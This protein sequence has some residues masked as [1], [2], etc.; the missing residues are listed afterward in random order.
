LI[1]FPW[2]IKTSA[3]CFFILTILGVI[4]VIFDTVEINFNIF[5]GL[6]ELILKI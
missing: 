2:V 4:E 6:F 3:L 1:L 5:I